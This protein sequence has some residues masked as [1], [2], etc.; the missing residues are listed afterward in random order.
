MQSSAQMPNLSSMAI[1]IL[2]VPT[3]SASVER[4][5]S[6]AGR[7]NSV[8]R[9]SLGVSALNE[10]CIIRLIRFLFDNIELSLSDLD[11]DH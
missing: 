1:D 2:S 4:I 3:W 11:F 10:E 8:S 5:F 6:A 9:P 7:A